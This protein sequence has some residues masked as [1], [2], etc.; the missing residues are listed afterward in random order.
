MQRNR[1][2]FTSSKSKAE[3]ATSVITSSEGSPNW[4][5]VEGRPPSAAEYVFKL[6]YLLYL[7]M[8]ILPISI[9]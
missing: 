6:L 8:F 3:E 4:G 5:A 2:Q 1:G 9:I 7:Y